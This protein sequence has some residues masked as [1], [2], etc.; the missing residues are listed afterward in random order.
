MAQPLSKIQHIFDKIEGFFKTNKFNQWIVYKQEDLYVAF[1]D[2]KNVWTL[3]TKNILMIDFDFKDNITRSQ[4]IQIMT[5]YT[6]TMHKQGHDLLFEMFDTDR[7]VHAFLVN[8]PMLYND[9]K[10]LQIMLDI[11]Q[12]PYYI[13]FSKIL[14]FC[15]RLS[16]KVDHHSDHHIR[17]NIVNQ[18]FISKRFID[19]PYIGYGTPDPHIQKILA[20]QL[21]LIDWFKY[22]YQNRLLE[23]TSYY[24]VGDHT[25][26]KMAPPE[27]FFEEVNHAVQKYLNK[28][29]L[30]KPTIPLNLRFNPQPP[31]YQNPFIKNKD[32]K[33]ISIRK[34]Y[35]I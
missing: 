7:G 28:L 10:T 18:E 33:T 17:Q 31:P 21:L 22:Q 13:G 4:V 5:T 23:L 20:L 1:G 6:D 3:C 24:Y 11:D 19:I 35:H 9:P 12:D 30:K 32:N 15:M 34:I 26:Y 29:N 25:S 2:R 16:A 27:S 14:G 8:K